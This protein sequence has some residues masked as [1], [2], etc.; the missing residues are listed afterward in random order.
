MWSYSL[1]SGKSLKYDLPLTND[2]YVPRIK[3]TAQTNRIILYTMNRHQN[4]LK[5][6]AANPTDGRC[7]LLIEERVPKYVKEEA[8]EGITILKDYILFPSDRD[9][10][11]KLYLYNKDGKLLRQITNVN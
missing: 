11:T 2:M 1:S 4:E 8:M 9:G 3:T 6:Y 7:S 5:L 10:Y